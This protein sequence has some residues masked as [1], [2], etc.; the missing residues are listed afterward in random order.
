MRV[1]LAQF[2]GLGPNPPEELSGSIND[3]KEGVY[4]IN[5]DEPIV[6]DGKKENYVSVSARHGGYPVSR[7]SKR[8]ILAVGGSFESGRGFISLIAK[9]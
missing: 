1:R 7:I 9:K 3:F 2:D 6:L 8:G 4:R 5:F